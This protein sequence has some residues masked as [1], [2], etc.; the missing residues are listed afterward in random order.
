MSG[1]IKPENVKP[2]RVLGII[3]WKVIK[4]F[5]GKETTVFTGPLPKA[6][7]YMKKIRDSQRKGCQ[8]NRGGGKQPVSYTLEKVVE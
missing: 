3:M 5:N 1:P 2:N 4:K 8:K 7:A 6:R